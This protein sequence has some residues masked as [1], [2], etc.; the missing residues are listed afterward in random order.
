V[1]G[2]PLHNPWTDQNMTAGDVENI[3]KGLCTL[4]PV[5]NLSGVYV[6]EWMPHPRWAAQSTHHVTHQIQ[7]STVHTGTSNSSVHTRSQLVTHLFA[8]TMIA[9]DV[10]G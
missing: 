4:D 6:G 10:A 2:K 9:P 1:Q 8:A 7:Q 3:K 5:A